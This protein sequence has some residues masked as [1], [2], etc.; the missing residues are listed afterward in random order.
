MLVWISCF[1]I[2][3]LTHTHTHTH[4]QRKKFVENFAFN[5]MTHTEVCENTISLAKVTSISLPLFI[6]TLLDRRLWFGAKVVSEVK[7]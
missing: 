6:I 4:V 3:T 2:F 7:A 1:F 5:P